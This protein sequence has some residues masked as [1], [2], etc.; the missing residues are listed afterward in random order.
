[1]GTDPHRFF[2]PFHLDAVN[3]QLW[4]DNREIKLRRKTFDVLLYLVDHPGELVTKAALLDAIWA[5]VSVSDTMPATCVAELRKALGDEARVP[6]FIETVHGRGYRFIAKFKTPAIGASIRRPPSPRSS[7]TIMVG[8]HD[9]LALLRSW[10][11]LVAE[12]RRQVIFVAGEAGIGKT[13]FVEAVL[14]SIAQEGSAYIGR[15][16]CVEQY[17]AGEPYMPVLDALSRLG[18]EPGGDRLVELL[19]R[20]APTWLAQMPALLAPE[21]R[22]RLLA[23]MQGVTQQRML[24]EMTEALEAFAADAPLVLSVEDLHWSDFSTLELIA[25]IA[26]RNELARLLIIGTYRPVE[27]LAHEHPLG[28]MKQELELHRHC[29]ELRLKLLTESDVVDYL[30]KRVNSDVSSRIGKLAPVVHAL[31]DGNPLF[32]VNMVD[33]LLVDAGLLANSRMSEAEWAETLRAHRLDALRSIRQM[34]ERNLE[35]L[36]PEDQ[37]ILEVASAAGTEFSS[38]SI[39]AALECSQDEV[40]SR[41]A[42]LSRREQFVSE[43]GPITWPDGTVATSFRFHHS[44]YKEVLYGRLPL[45]RRYQLHRRIAMRQEA[46]Y[47]EH[48]SEIATELAHHY[49]CANSKDKAI[50]YFRVAGERAVARAAVIEAGGH[51]RSA[52]ELLSELPHTEE[53]DRQELTLQVALGT[54]LLDSEN[55]SHPQTATVFG[56]AEE[57]AKRLGENIQLVSALLGLLISCTG[58]G[59]FRLAR[60]VA[61]RM[62]RA[63]EASSDPDSLSVAHTFLGETLMEAAQYGDAQ[64]HLELGS[65]FC[66]ESK[67]SGLGG[68]GLIAPAL[69]SNV[70]LVLGFA[71]RARTL[72][73]KTLRDTTRCAHYHK[74]GGLRLWLGLFF[75]MLRDLTG[76]L[77]NAHAMKEMALKGPVWSG[78]ADYFAGRAHM[79]EGN[80]REAATYLQKAIAFQ[81]SVGL[82]GVLRFLKLDHVELLAHMGSIDAAFALVSEAIN[83]QELPHLWSLSLRQRADLL[84]QS[85]ADISA[86][87]E[88]YRTAIECARGQKARYYEL[89]ATTHFARW[90]KSR[91][92][93]AEAKTVLD[94]IYGWFTEGFDAPAL[95]EA[96]TLLDELSTKSSAR[97]RSNI[98]RRDH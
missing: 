21:E 92:R 27:I 59:R 80:W 67:S 47:G 81:D 49:D 45:A 12:G 20:F 40:E 60:E 33:Y 83:D 52:L 75:G 25:A 41:C 70:L 38:T 6:R 95:E 51:Y 85:N 98:S 3:A 44:L 24:R 79:L 19:K 90:L 13:T 86:I 84:V 10:H 4:R 22:V 56:R 17:G 78:L 30:A 15:G 36:K 14:D 91:G 76:T 53:R 55:W 89:Q 5:E 69:L 57:L 73:K 42:R 54:V 43:Q 31:T 94:E 37:T 34:I 7:R 64:K 82:F 93:T 88:A 1:V 23:E 97:R 65:R 72:A 62:L 28:T 48:A 16:Q 46:G 35:R 26:R 71:D 8:R 74:L 50:H 11:A 87:E 96:K 58:S 61:E 63:A 68:W 2:P 39:A 18:Q 32:I 66:D 9:E 29:Q 77:E